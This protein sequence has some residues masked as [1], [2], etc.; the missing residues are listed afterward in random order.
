MGGNSEGYLDTVP[1]EKDY[2]RVTTQDNYAYHMGNCIEDWMI[3]EVSKLEKPDQILDFKLETTQ[4][5]AKW[6]YFFKTKLFGK[7]ILN[8]KIMTFFLIWKGLRKEDA[9]NYLT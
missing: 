8:K 5:N 9:K 3:E 6:L 2:W 1:L 4:C 7:F